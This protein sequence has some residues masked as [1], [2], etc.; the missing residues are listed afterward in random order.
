MTEHLPERRL[1][2]QKRL[3]DSL[4]QWRRSGSTQVLAFVGPVGSGRRTLAGHVAAALLCLKPD[5]ETLAPCGT[6]SSCRY[7]A[8]GTHPDFIALRSE[9]AGKMIRIDDVRSRVIAD[10]SMRPQLGARKVYLLDADAL[11]EGSQ[12]ALLKTLEEPPSY[13]YILLT[14]RRAANLLSTV[15]SRATLFR[16]DP[17]TDEELEEVLRENG[18][19]DPA[20]V[21]AAVEQASGLPGR[22]LAFAMDE[23]QQEAAKEAG[24]FFTERLNWD[25]ATHLTEGVERFR[26]LHR[27]GDNSRNLLWLNEAEGWLRDLLYC[28]NE[29]ALGRAPVPGRLGR[30]ERLPVLRQYGQLGLD[31]A[32]I[33]KAAEAVS[34]ARMSLSPTVNGNLELTAS[35]LMLVLD[36]ELRKHA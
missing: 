26:K 19:E 21:R 30:Q 36:K 6:C 2:G 18:I 31:Q 5:P 9:E 11:A 3:L 10:L 22:A 27:P 35:R 12:N 16:L 1:I 13:A 33:G 25:Q 4:G 20:T 14:V 23:S 24:R 7:L 17:L 29:Q 8:A 28:I 15:R 32:S 34:D